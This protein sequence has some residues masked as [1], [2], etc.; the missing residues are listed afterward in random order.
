MYIKFKEITPSISHNLSWLA[1]YMYKVQ[2]GQKQ[3]KT[4]LFP[5]HSL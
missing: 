1:V 5:M 4:E 3:N 2:D